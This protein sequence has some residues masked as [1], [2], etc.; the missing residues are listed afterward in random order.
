MQP[1]SRVKPNWTHTDWGSDQVMIRR[2]AVAVKVAQCIAE[3]AEIESLIGM[4]LAMLLHANQKAIL[5]IYSALDNRAAQLRMINAAATTSLPSHHADLVSV[6]VKLDIRPAMKYR[7]KLAHWCW[8]HS[9]DLPDALLLREPSDK[10]A[11]LAD[12][13]NHQHISLGRTGTLGSREMPMNADQVFVLKETDLDRVLKQF[14]EAQ[15][16]LRILQGSV[17]GI[18]SPQLRAGLLDQLAA[19]PRFRAELDRLAASRNTPP[20][21]PPS[22]APEQSGES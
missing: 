5:A 16:N 2:P 6:S 7:D 15:L 22:P 1:L 21:Q 14:E 17:W 10:L 8:G 13:I 12:F 11:N 18:N 20:T 3:W 19:K 9:D 4:F